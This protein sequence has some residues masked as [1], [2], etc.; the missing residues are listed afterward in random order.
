MEKTFSKIEINLIK[1]QAKNAAPYVAKKQKIDA[2][3][4]E[5]EEKV[6]EQIR[7]RAQEKIEKLEAEKKSYQTIIDSMNQTVK[8]IT[9]G[10]TTEDL[11]ISKKEGTGNIDPNTGKEIM[12]TV[13]V[14]KYPETVVPPT[15]D[16]IVPP[17]T[18]DG[19]GSDYD[20][21]KQASEGVEEMPEELLA[22]KAEAAAEAENTDPFIDDPVW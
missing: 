12:K 22:E 17:T 18:E 14:L 9:G 6:A 15:E 19:P 7:K 2:Q 3:I 13:Y 1:S 20:K 21:D 11:V 4:K 5:V 10:Y 16:T 8:T